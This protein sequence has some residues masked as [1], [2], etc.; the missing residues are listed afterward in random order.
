MRERPL[1]VVTGASSGIGLS[2]AKLCASQGYDLILAADEPEIFAAAAQVRSPE[3]R[4]WEIQ[5]DLSTMAGVDAL[6]DLMPASILA[7]QNRRLSA[8]ECMR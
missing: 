2:I 1:A 5:A 7:W 6:C 4:V 3:T 8:P